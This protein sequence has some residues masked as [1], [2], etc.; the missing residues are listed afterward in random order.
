MI[1][2]IN[3]D[4]SVISNLLDVVRHFTGCETFHKQY[5]KNNKQKSVWRENRRKEEKEKDRERKVFP[6]SLPVGTIFMRETIAVMRKQVNSCV[7]A[8][9]KRT[10]K[11]PR[12][13]GN[14]DYR[15]GD[16]E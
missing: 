6:W 1:H 7:C 8:C 14:R 15:D 16:G 4:I 13:F 12:E 5:N 10:D 3:S 9:G 11:I 2:F